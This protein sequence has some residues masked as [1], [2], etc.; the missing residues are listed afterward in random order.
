MAVRDRA[1]PCDRPLDDVPQHAE[2]RLREDIAAFVEVDVEHIDDER[3][4][5]LRAGDRDRPGRGVG[6]REP[7]AVI[8]S[9]RFHVFRPPQP[10]TA[11]VVVSIT[12]SVGAVSVRR[13]GRLASIA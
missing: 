13:G 8:R 10:P 2:V 3:I 6:A 12:T 9:R 4:A 5:R 1:H 11:R 7:V